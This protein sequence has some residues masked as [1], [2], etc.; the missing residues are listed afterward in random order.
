MHAI[1]QTYPLESRFR[2]RLAATTFTVVLIGA[3]ILW[4]G[5]IGIWH[6]GQLYT[7]QAL[8]HL[9]PTLFAN[10]L[11][12]RFGS[13]DD[14]TLFS[15]LYAGAIRLLGI[16]HAAALLTL[17]F[18]AAFVASAWLLARKLL[19]ARL[20]WL[21]V[22]LVIGTRGDYGTERVFTFMEDFITPRM[23]AEAWVLAGL[24]AM[25]AG[26]QVWTALCMV[27]A[28]L[29]HPLM[30]VAGLA[31]IFCLHV[32]I[33]RP[34]LAAVV[35]VLG[36][37]L[38]IATA[39][40]PLGARLRFGHEWL[41][42]VQR[43]GYLFVTEWDVRDGGR[44]VIS[45]TTLVVG[46]LTLAPSPARSFCGAGLLLWALGIGFTL[47]G[48]DIL[49]FAVIAQAQPWRCLWISS[50]VAVLLLPLVVR[51]CWRM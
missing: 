7:F 42:L 51:N 33:P 35:C 44:V 20:V 12:L 17:L 38:L 26:R 13:Q 2:E 36:A 14:Y 31:F 34:R 48:V 27:A 43:E 25:L 23:A 39:A 29:L 4:H 22:A 47:L 50:V 49:H 37:C 28:M 24:T 6:D 32:A 45:A 18:Q 16:E 11:F 21:A 8:A 19:P 3:W 9:H 40:S 5:Y 1:T 46:A 15:P 10:D 41:E 30:G